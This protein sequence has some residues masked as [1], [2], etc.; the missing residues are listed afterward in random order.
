M[1]SIILNSCCAKLNL[2]IFVQTDWQR[3]R[4]YFY[5]VFQNGLFLLF[6]LPA[7]LL[8]AQ[9]CISSFPFNESFEANNGG[10][11][12]GGSS[13]DWAWGTPSKPVIT[14]AGG[15]NRC[16]ITGGLTI[17][18]YNNGENSFL[19]SPC[20]NLS[21][22]A[23]PQISFKIFWETEK[24][25]DG[26]ALQYTTDGGATWLILGNTNSNTNCQGE[27]WYNTTA[28]TY[29]GNQ[30]GWSGNIQPNSG[31][32]ASG[33]GGGS[34]A[35]LVAK[36]NLS[37]LAGQANVRFRFIFGAGTICNAY[38]G[39]AI[40]DIF[41]GEAPPNTTSI[42]STCINEN[43]I[44]FSTSPNCVVS[45]AWNF[46]DPLSGAANTVSSASPQHQFTGP[47][48]YTVSLTT[49]FVSGPPVTV[50]KNIVII[51]LANNVQWPGKC[52]GAADATLSVTA[53]GSST[54]YFFNWDTSPTQTTSSITGMGPGTY[55]LTANAANACS[56][57]TSFVLD[58]PVPIIINPAI[59]DAT[60][61]AA[62][63]S[64]STNVTGGKSPYQYTWSN[65]S[66]TA[67]IQNL[68]SGSYSLSVTDANGCST[69]AG[70]LIVKNK[71]SAVP[72]TLGADFSIC[73]G[74]SVTLNPGNFAGYLW[75]DN[76]ITPTY[77]VSAAGTY[78]VKVSDAAGCSGADTVNVT[79]DCSGVYFPSAF[80]PNGDSKNDGFG[81]LGNLAAVKKYELSVYDRYGQRVFITADPFKKWNGTFKESQFNTGSFVWMASF[82]LNGKKAFY[83]GTVII[84][85]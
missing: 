4:H 48:T 82:E 9:P 37:A 5:K 22:I 64:I 77:T 45:Y 16:W 80:T 36:H 79:A 59:T 42:I 49:N 28:I 17:P 38:D 67:T 56:A 39:F 74:Q 18:A 60:C 47:G 65:A 43:Q 12:P 66:N 21:G 68:L 30:A 23:S 69:S 19:L 54:G 73:P 2:P 25:F 81:A 7:S 15:G 71:N 83:K 3:M 29:L 24:R 33:S 70:S 6:L 75:Q 14:A 41:I 53:S 52:T 31:S 10:W 1:K 13:S 34:G 62:N 20:F 8:C 44:A 11:T 61:G 50:T 63:G 76:S 55:T 51:G 57:S 35:W 84:I 78:F 72:V 40:D 26:A 32:C 27:N 85:R 46:G 58:A